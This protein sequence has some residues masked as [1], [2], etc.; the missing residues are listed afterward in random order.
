MTLSQW[1]LSL[2]NY[3]RF[4]IC[5]KRSAKKF[6]YQFHAAQIPHGPSVKDL[7]FDHRHINKFVT[8][9]EK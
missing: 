7:F 2:F 6:W 3:H 9:K 1:L 4:W 5:P 8:K